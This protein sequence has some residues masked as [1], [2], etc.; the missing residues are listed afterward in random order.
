[1]PHRNRE[2]LTA[3]RRCRLSFCAATFVLL[4]AVTSWADDGRIEEIVVHSAGLEGNLLGDSADRSV[5]VYLPPGYDEEPARAYP[6]VYNLSGF[7]GVHDAEAGWYAP[8]LSAE[9][10]AGAIRPMIVVFIDGTNRL[11][12]SNYA[13][14]SVEGAWEDFVAVD[15]VR[16]IDAQ[17][18]TIPTAS[19]RGIA[20]YSMGAG[21]AMT[22]AIKRADVFCAV[23]STKGHME[24]PQQRSYDTAWSA[25][26]NVAQ[27]D[28]SIENAMDAAWF[29]YPLVV[30]FSPNPDN[31]PLYV[32]LPYERVDGQ[33]L[34]V[35]PAYSRMMAAFPVELLDHYADSAAQLRGVSFIAATNDMS[36]ILPSSRALSEALSQAGIDHQFEEV[37]G[38]HSILFPEEWCN[39][40]MRFFSD[41]LV[42]EAVPS[43]VEAESWGLVKS[44]VR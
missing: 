29:A 22:L 26:I 11:G 32:D 18:R 28:G 37:E 7:R 35:E 39:R 10:T 5:A 33:L 15:V 44:E 31:A 14:S 19:G 12:G 34:P 4:A 13:N 30:A 23:Y 27:Y 20:G 38:D 1:M 6:V 25:L 21:G 17:Y 36:G 41:I 40:T 24:F 9:I 2:R 16:H 8:T 42:P 3:T 43:A